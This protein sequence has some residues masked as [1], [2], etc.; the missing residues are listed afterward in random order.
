MI[1]ETKEKNCLPIQNSLGKN[2]MCGAPDYIRK[3]K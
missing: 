1:A 2:K 3:K